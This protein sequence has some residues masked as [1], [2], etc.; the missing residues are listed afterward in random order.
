MGVA[1]RGRRYWIRALEVYSTAGG[2]LI[3]SGRVGLG[4]SRE[5]RRGPRDA[6]W[7]AGWGMGCG[8]RGGTGK[9][10]GAGWSGDCVREG[11]LGKDW[12][13]GLVVL[14]GRRVC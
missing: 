2:A 6:S 11:E 5:K 3:E 1:W 13:G 7:W 9:G 4:R 10:G 12:R 8:G 14:V